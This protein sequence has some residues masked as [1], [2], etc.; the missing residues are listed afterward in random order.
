MVFVGAI[1]DRPLGRMEIK[2][3]SR[4]FARRFVYAPF[5]FL[6]LRRRAITDRPYEEM[7]AL[8]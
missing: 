7:V 1:S 6:G 3:D 8:L 5:D 2:A 4:S